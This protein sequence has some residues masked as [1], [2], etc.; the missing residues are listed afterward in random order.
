L[1]RHGHIVRMRM[2]EA[3]N[4]QPFV[5]RVFLAAHQLFGPNQKAIALGFSSRAFEIG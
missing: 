2:I 4:L 1:R 3:D 5:T